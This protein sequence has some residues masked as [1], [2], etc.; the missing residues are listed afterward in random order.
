M[1]LLLGALLIFGA[2]F[3]VFSAVGGLSAER[4]GSTGRSRCSRR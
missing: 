4:Q 2:L 3:L 1:V